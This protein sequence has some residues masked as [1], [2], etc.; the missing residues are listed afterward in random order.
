MVRV[1]TTGYISSQKATLREFQA[2][3][4]IHVL[5]QVNKG[6]VVCKMSTIVHSRSKWVKS[7]PRSCWMIP[8]EVGVKEAKPRFIVPDWSIQRSRRIQANTL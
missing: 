1:D 2:Y 3:D 7:D 8:Y 4:L 5:G 6:Y